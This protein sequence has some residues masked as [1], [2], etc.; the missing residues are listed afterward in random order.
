MFRSLKIY[1]I[2]T[3]LGNFAIND[4]LRECSEMICAENSW[5][6]RFE[7]NHFREWFFRI[8]RKLLC[9]TLLFI[10]LRL[11]PNF[12]PICLVPFLDMTKYLRISNVLKILKNPCKSMYFTE[13]LWRIYP[14]CLILPNIFKNRVVVINPGGLIGKL[15][16]KDL[17]EKRRS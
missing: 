4:Y 9:N 17:Y 15:T 6:F 13:I 16:V 7:F 11:C 2:L 12:S 14:K 1:Q 3:F 5:Y 10:G 8:Y